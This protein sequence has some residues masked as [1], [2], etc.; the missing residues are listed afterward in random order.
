ML[1]HTTLSWPELTETGRLLQ[2]DVHKALE[3]GGGRTTVAPLPP[4]FHQPWRV[5]CSSAMRAE[6]L[7][8]YSIRCTVATSETSWLMARL[9]SMNRYRRLCLPPL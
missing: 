1:L 5:C 3:S 7:G 6:R 8:S 4:P 9:R 2:R